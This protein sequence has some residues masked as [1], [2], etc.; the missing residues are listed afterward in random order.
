MKG[1]HASTKVIFFAPKC[2]KHSKNELI[3]YNPLYARFSA[4][5]SS[6]AVATSFLVCLT[7]GKFKGTL[8]SADV[9]RAARYVLDL[10]GQQTSITEFI[11]NTVRSTTFEIR[12]FKGDLENPTYVNEVKLKY[13]IKIES[14]NVANLPLDYK[15]YNIDDEANPVEIALTNNISDYIEVSSNA[16]I[17]KYRLDVIWQNGLDEVIYANLTDEINIVVDAEQI[18]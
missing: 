1:K 6:L 5:L 17:H 13:T 2:G 16:Q 4:C 3:V 11:P 12:N 7:F 15:L 18:D 9:A 14:V 8:A 10:S